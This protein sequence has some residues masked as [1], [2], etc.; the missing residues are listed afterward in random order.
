MTSLVKKE[1]SG[2]KSIREQLD[3]VQAGYPLTDAASLMDK[4]TK[5]DPALKKRILSQATI[6]RLKQA[7]ADAPVLKKT[8]SEKVARIERIWVRVLTI[9]QND[10]AAAGIFMNRPHM[11][12]A[13]KTPLEMTLAGGTSAAF[14]NTVL[15]TIENGFAA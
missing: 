8:L 15:G 13:G 1:T 12:L 11:M 9:Y 3:A 5:G 6:T 4:V 7:R 2:V 14:L 10:E